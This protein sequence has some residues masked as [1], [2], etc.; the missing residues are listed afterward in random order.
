MRKVPLAGAV[1]AVLLAVAG[2][3]WISAASQAAETSTA[4]SRTL[5]FD[6]VFS[7]ARSSG[8]EQRP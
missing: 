3:V 6:V 1:A 4:K 7:P 2:V 5:S 8:R